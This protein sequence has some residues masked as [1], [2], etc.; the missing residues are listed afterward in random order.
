MK[1]NNK[2][3]RQG[4]GVTFVILFTLILLST[5]CSKVLDIKPTSSYT[6]S[7]FFSNVNQANMAILGVYRV[8]ATDN[9]YGLRINMY[10]NADT[11]ESRVSG[12]DDDGRRGLGRYVLTSANSE[13]EQPFYSLYSGVE[14][15][16][17]CIDR[18]PK[19]DLYS[20]GTETEIKTLKRYYA[21]ALVLRSIF[22][23]DLVRHW[24]DVPFVTKPSVAGE[25]FYLPRTSRDTIYDHIIKDMQFVIN[26]SMLD[27]T[28]PEP[29][30]RL[31]LGAVK[32]LLARFCLHA[33]GYSLRWNL[34]DNS[35]VSVR[36]RDDATR[37]AELYQIARAETNSIISSGQHSL[38][39]S[40]EKVFR[41]YATGFLDPKESMFE[42]AFYLISNADG[43]NFGGQVSGY[44]GLQIDETTKF[45][46]GANGIQC[47]PSYYYSFDP[48]DSRK[49]LA[50]SFERIQLK[51]PA[52]NYIRTVQNLSTLSIGKWRKDWITTGIKDRVYTDMNW[53][54]LRYS[55]VLLMNAEADNELNQGPGAEAIKNFEEVRKRAFK[56][57][58]YGN[59]SSSLIG[60][61]PTDYTGFFNA[62]VNERSWE[63]GHEGWR[64]NDLI[65]WNIMA[66]RL[67]TC[68]TEMRKIM[69]GQGKY[70]TMVPVNLYYIYDSAKDSLKVS[71]TA[72][73]GYTKVT[74]RANIN[75]ADV[76]R[77]GRSYTT[78]KH[79][80]LPIHQAI[81]STN[82]NLKQHPG[83]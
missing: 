55:D 74:W 75:E 50:G 30:E 33:A 25:D 26:E 9:L 64:K 46:R 39:I 57:A 65:R 45:T 7:N 48:K 83:Y 31:G 71:E 82:P 15:A 13:L 14:R 60:T 6:S 32:G 35:N 40:Y 70:A 37:I 81:I 69:N 16:N 63:L 8:L 18:I 11:D 78:N 19:M 77:T 38:N 53:V 10:Y 59:A 47:V 68:R 36:K 2:N 41:N 49:P 3:K 44:N 17:I 34:D 62:L 27:W 29:C 4:V 22:Y 20:K 66:S 61:T 80:L 23:F 12:S 56:V 73:T 24:G 52:P 21:E 76:L 72:Q 1:I 58:P 42:V 28:E 79:E 51:A 54:L 5:S 43:S 67:D